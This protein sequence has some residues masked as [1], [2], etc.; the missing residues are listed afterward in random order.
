MRAAEPS[1][2]SVLA[3]LKAAGFPG[4]VIP[5]NASADTVQGLP[6]IASLKD[7]RGAVDLAG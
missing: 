4:R 3:N 7:A 2:G 6:A 5:V 1:G